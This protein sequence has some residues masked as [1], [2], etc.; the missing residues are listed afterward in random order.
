MQKTSELLPGCRFRITYTYDYAEAYPEA[1][2]VASSVRFPGFRKGHAPFGLVV[3]SYGMD[4]LFDSAFNRLRPYKELINDL[5]EEGHDSHFPPT[6]TLKPVK[7]DEPVVY[8]CVWSIEPQIEIGEYQ[9][10]KLLIPEEKATDEMVEE[11]IKLELRKQTSFSNVTDRPCRSGEMVTVD[12]AGTIDG[13]EVEGTSG[14]DVSFRIG[15][16]RYLPDLE[17]GIVGMSV[18]EEKDIQVL[19]PEDYGNK[20]LAGKTVTFHVKLKA[21]VEENVPELDDDYVQDVSDFDTVEEYREDMRR[22]LEKE[23]EQKNKT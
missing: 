3:R 16:R 11:R 14:N 4:V 2:K 19:F 23:V 10:T 8:E 6:I 18:D 21:I 5:L 9:G 1:Y 22:V 17:D 20:D 12:F 15:E 7:K 13:V